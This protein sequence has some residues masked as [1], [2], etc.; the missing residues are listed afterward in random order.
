MALA[1]VQPNVA[2]VLELSGLADALL[3]ADDVPAAIRLIERAD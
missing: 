2:R 1:C 3:V